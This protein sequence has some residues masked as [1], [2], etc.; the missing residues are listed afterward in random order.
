M[1][2]QPPGGA[3]VG[4]TSSDDGRRPPSRRPESAPASDPHAPSLPASWDAAAL[5]RLEELEALLTE[6]DQLVDALTVQ[7]ED[8]AER[9]DRLQRSG[10][11][12]GSKSVGGIPREFLEEQ[13]QLSASLQTVVQQW[14][15]AQ[16]VATLGRIEM[17]LAE[18]R[19]LVAGNVLAPGA[20]A[21]PP[22]EPAPMPASGS[23]F[24]WDAV[25]A[26]L[27]GSKDEPSAGDPSAAQAAPHEDES[28]DLTPVDAPTTIDSTTATAEELRAAVDQRDAYIVWLL[29]RLRSMDLRL[30]QRDATSGGDAPPE[31]ARRLEELERVFQEQ[32]RLAEV[33]LSMER[34]RLGREEMRL[35]HLEESLQK[36]LTRLGISAGQDKPPEELSKE[37]PKNRRWRRI[38]GVVRQD[39]E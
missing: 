38:L 2:S 26:S 17:Q 4:T 25:K 30:A 13:Q 31:L 15:E 6:K 27:M 39:E 18:L 32:Q 16:P 28:L 10:N 19:D 36:E 34:A 8:A 9:I 23:G 11:D 3:A 22:A 29:R 12:R 7:L 33:E 37:S 35:K 24:A 5:H 21:Q 20:A 1:S 14:E